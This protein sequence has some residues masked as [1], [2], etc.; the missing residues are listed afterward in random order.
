MIYHG[1]GSVEGATGLFL[2]VLGQYGMVL[3]GT[4]WYWVS[5]TWYCLVLSGTGLVQGFHACIYIENS[6][7]LVGCHHSGTDGRTKKER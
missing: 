4:W 3:V 1:T 2:V 5:V 7:D 6:G